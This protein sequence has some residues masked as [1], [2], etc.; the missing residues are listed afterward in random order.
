MTSL[1]R[2]TL[3]LVPDDGSPPLDRSE[4]PVALKGV[5]S[6][7]A[8]RPHAHVDEE[9]LV[10]ATLRG[11]RWAQ[12][13]IWYRFAPMIHGLLR[14]SLHSRHDTDDLTQEVF[15]RVFRRLH[16]LEKASALRSF[17]YSVGVRVVCEEIRQFKI[18]RRA[19]SQLALL[20][21]E[22]RSAPC[23][24][25]ARDALAQIQKLLDGMKDKHRAVFVLRHVEGMELHEIATGLSISM[26]SVKRYLVSALRTIQRAVAADRELRSSLGLSIDEDGRGTR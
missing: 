24:F 1:A 12:R 19:H 2:A 17:V 13:E 22:N 6:V 8:P 23:N 4:A 16:S 5:Q 9:T 3:E 14:R 10:A 21:M 18:L 15:L 25:E 7:D 11:E 20:D 26:A